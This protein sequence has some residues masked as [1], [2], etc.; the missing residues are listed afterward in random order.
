MDNLNLLFA[1]VFIIYF[2][3]IIVI[4]ILPKKRSVAML[5]LFGATGSFMLCIF[6]IF[7]LFRNNPYFLSLWEIR[8]IGKMSITVDHLSAFFLLVASI[9]AMPASVFASTRISKNPQNYNTFISAIYLSL[10]ISIVLVLVASNVFFFLLSW[11]VMSIFIYF[12]VNSGDKE[13]PGYVMLAIGEAG[14][15]AILVALV[16]L[17]KNANAFSFASISANGYNLNAKLQWIVFLLSFFGFGIKG[18]IIPFNFWMPR[19]YS[20]TPSAF[21]PIIAG[22]TLNLGL[23]GIIRVNTNLQFI[24]QTSIGI[25]ILITGAITA[26]LGILY[27]TI[28]DDLKTILAHS[29][30]ENAGIITTAFGASIVFL[31]SGY[32]TASAIAL[33]AAL[34]HLLNHSIFKTL[35]FMGSGVIEDATGSR[36]LNQMGGLLKKMPWTGFFMLVGVLSISAMPPFN[37]FVSEWLVLESLLRSAEFSSLGVKIAFIIAGALLALTAGLAVTCF[38]RAFAMSFLGI[39]R[40]NLMQKAKEV[41]KSTMTSMAFLA[42]V[43]LILGILPTFIIPTINKSVEPIVGKSAT[44]A[45]VPPFFTNY[46]SK[47]ELPRKF[48]SAFHDIGAGVGED[49]VSARGLVVMHRGGKANPVIFAMS[50]SYMFVM[51]IFLLV[52]SAVLVWIFAKRK[53]KVVYLPRWDGGIKEL[54]PEMTYTATGFAQ[55]V[56]VIF[57]T[58]LHPEVTNQHESVA[59]HFRVTIRRKKEEVHLIDRFVLYP[60]MDFTQKLSKILAK[61]HNGRLNA[62]AGY[63]LLS[64]LIALIIAFA[65]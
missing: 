12:L 31:S 54:F 3:G 29:S 5:G 19:A 43:C 20:V 61:M 41:T 2:I 32:K 10:L 13:H 62:Y 6:S 60:V 59:E 11:E 39:S 1:S 51:M 4:L 8:G 56:R 7:V 18:G 57:D 15:L 52:I 65:R 30:M 27:A 33:V 26:I 49:L 36:S 25:V 48:V 28:E 53:R 50:T 35:L 46:N 22:V 58:I 16:L 17:A 24:S 40:T 63:T 21:I 9:A 64:I 42:F 55:P 34:Y 14:T 23:Y 37:G 47:D 44:V 38:V 45:L